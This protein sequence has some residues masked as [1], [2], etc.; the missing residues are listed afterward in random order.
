MLANILLV[1]DSHYDVV[2]TKI[3]LERDKVIANIIA[4]GDGREALAYLGNL[5]PFENASKP[6]LI[7]LDLN[8]PDINGFKVLKVMVDKD[9]LRDIPVIICSGS[10]SERDLD[11][12][13]G[14]G[15]IDY[16]VKPIEYARLA[17]ILARIP[18]LTVNVTDEHHFIC[19]CA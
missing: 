16:L 17:P 14:F 5:P 6:D 19:R 18:K 9:W 1:D 3:M 11:T 15:V 12:A 13:R 4:V 10:D 7:L 2:L 8:M